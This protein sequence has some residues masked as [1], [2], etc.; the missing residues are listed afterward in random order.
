MHRGC[1]KYTLDMA[2]AACKP[3]MM[4]CCPS[5]SLGLLKRPE[6][7]YYILS[8]L[9]PLKSKT[10]SVNQTH[11]STVGH[12]LFVQSEVQAFLCVCCCL[13][14]AATLIRKKP[15][16]AKHEKALWKTQSPFQTCKSS[17]PPP[18]NLITVVPNTFFRVIPTSLPI[19][20]L[21]FL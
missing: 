4:H 13:S 7:G 6:R 10:S 18:P 14:H 16:E 1:G 21:L 2:K 8:L 9:Y 12:S 17:L 20:S 11:F 5:E 3:G 15:N 19:Q